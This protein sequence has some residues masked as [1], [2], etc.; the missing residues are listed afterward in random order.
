MFLERLFLRLWLRLSGSVSYF[1]FLPGDL[2]G[3]GSAETHYSNLV[4]Y[5]SPYLAI[6]FALKAPYR[7]SL[8]EQ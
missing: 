2:I 6:N 1:F 3:L 8:L 4:S 5:F 7:I